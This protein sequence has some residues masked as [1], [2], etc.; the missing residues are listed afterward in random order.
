VINVYTD[1][2]VGCL[3]DGWAFGIHFLAWEKF[4]L[5]YTV[6]RVALWPLPASYPVGFQGQFPRVVTI[7]PNLP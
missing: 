2:A 7:P 5:F 1:V 4:N 6:S 3:L